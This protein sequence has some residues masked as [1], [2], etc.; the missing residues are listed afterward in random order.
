MSEQLVFTSYAEILKHA[1]KVVGITKKDFVSWRRFRTLVVKRALIYSYLR[2]I[3]SMSYPEIAQIANRDHSS[4]I[5]SI[6]KYG[7]IYLENKE[8]FLCQ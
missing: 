3:H 5:H 4:V 7:D 1:R 8:K 2:D 6:K